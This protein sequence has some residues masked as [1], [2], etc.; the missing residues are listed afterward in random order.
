MKQ[1]GSNYE[2]A[3]VINRE[4][5]NRRNEGLVLG[6]LGDLFL[7]SGQASLAQSHFEQAIVICDELFPAAAGA[8]RGSLALI[9][10][11][12]GD[13]PAARRLL[14][15]G[16]EQLRGQHRLELGKLLCKRGTIEH[17]AGDLHTAH[18][19]RAE[20]SDIVE[21]LE[22]TPDSELGKA[23]TALQG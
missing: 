18:T 4:I 22:V 11:A 2:Q 8:F 21:A 17:S 10:S 3:L 1:A 7:F 15:C 20:A 14:A 23:V 12:Q 9:V 19:A 6:N 13:L 16:E 5:G